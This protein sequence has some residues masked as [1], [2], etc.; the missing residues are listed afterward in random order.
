MQMSL[1]LFLS[2]SLVVLLRNEVVYLICDYIV[3]RLDSIGCV[4]VCVCSEYCD[5]NCF[6]NK[7]SVFE[8]VNLIDLIRIAYLVVFKPICWYMC[9]CVCV[10]CVTKLMRWHIKAWRNINKRRTLSIKYHNNSNN[11]T[12]INRHLVSWFDCALYDFYAFTHKHT[13]AYTQTNRENVRFLVF[14]SLYLSLSVSLSV[15]P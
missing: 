2:I 12:Q 15:E 13:H 10:L 14:L 11:R 6:F 1:S 8:F 7:I 3:N 4:C 9:V 5:C